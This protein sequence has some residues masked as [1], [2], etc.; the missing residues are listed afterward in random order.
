MWN[1]QHKS[2]SCGFGFY[3][4]MTSVFCA[5]LDILTAVAHALPWHDTST[6]FGSINAVLETFL[7]LWD[8]VCVLSYIQYICFCNNSFL[9][10]KRINSLTFCW[11]TELNGS[12]GLP[13][14]LR[15]SLSLCLS[16]MMA[17]YSQEETLVICKR[18][19]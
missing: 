6:Q 19:I 5:V 8:W 15:F 10:K 12:P 17:Q 3:Q 11:L 16:W 13:W 18:L 7:L 9:L 4:N 2:K 14:S 1:R